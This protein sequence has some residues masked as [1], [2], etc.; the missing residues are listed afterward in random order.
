MRKQINYDTLIGRQGYD[1]I[2]LDYVFNHGDGFKGAT[3]TRMELVSKD[4]YDNA[5]EDT[6][7]WEERWRDAV[8]AKQT[9]QGLED[10]VEEL[11]TKEKEEWL[12]DNSYGDEL[13]DQIRALGY[14]EEEYPIIA[15]TG[16]GRCFS[17]ADTWDELYEPELW[18][19]IK[20]YETTEK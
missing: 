12:W 15:C 19:L 14:T 18:E 1:Y 13:R 6:D 20:E 7:R 5:M 17:V 8:A 3:G 10:W 11:S 16:G 2:F 4:E 9:E